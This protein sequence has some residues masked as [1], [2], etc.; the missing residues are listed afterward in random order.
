MD[1]LSPENVLTAGNRTRGSIPHQITV[2]VFP[3]ENNQRRNELFSGL[4][5]AMKVI[6]L[7]IYAVVR[8]AI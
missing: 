6:Q 4:I 5:A 7:L 1:L 3:W 2:P 8:E